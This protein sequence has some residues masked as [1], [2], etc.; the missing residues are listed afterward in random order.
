MDSQVAA[1]GEERGGDRWDNTFQE[2][3]ESREKLESVKVAVVSAV[4]GTVALLPLLFFG[5]AHYYRL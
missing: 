3:D 4:V 5:Y 1:V 2:V